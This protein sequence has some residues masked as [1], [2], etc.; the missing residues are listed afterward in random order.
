MYVDF[1][2]KTFC[3]RVQFPSSPQNYSKSTQMGAF[4]YV[5]DIISWLC[6]TIIGGTQHMNGVSSLNGKYTSSCNVA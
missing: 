1:F 5:L 6:Y 2:A 4:C 3:T